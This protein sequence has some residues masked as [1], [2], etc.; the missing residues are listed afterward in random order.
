MLTVY[1][2]HGH[3]QLHQCWWSYNN[4]L[5]IY[6]KE[7][8]QLKTKSSNCGSSF[9]SLVGRWLGDYNTWDTW[10]I[11]LTRPQDF[12]SYLNQDNCGWTMLLWCGHA[13][14]IHLLVLAVVLFCSILSG[15]TQF[16]LLLWCHLPNPI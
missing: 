2:R 7:H 3:A 15:A 9:F 6:W 1:C 10:Q 4:V 8:P 13:W 11:C 12:P 16:I 5:A 14:D